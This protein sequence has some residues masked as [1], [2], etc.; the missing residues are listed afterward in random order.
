MHG[1]IVAR[2]PQSGETIH[3]RDYV[4][5]LNNYPDLPEAEVSLQV[6]GDERTAVIPSSMPFTPPTVTV[7]GGDRFIIEGAST[8]PDGNTFH[9]VALLRMQGQKVIE[10]TSYFAAPF[11]PPEWRRSWVELD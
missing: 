7:F 2:F 9:V 5:M 8:Y 1:D 4:E 6:S 3:G 11:D 10:E